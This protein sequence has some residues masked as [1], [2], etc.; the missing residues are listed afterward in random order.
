MMGVLPLEFPTGQDAD[1]L[2][3]AGTETFDIAVDDTLTPGQDVQVTA[4]AADGA[5]VSFMTKARVDTPIEVDYLRHGGILQM[6]L[7]DM[8]AE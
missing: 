4:T 6:V 7:R 1:S 8:A 2:G 3:L 5:V